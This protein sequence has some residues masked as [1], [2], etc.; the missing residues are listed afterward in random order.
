MCKG[1]GL[2][3]GND[4][5]SNGVVGGMQ[6]DRELRRHTAAA[7]AFDLRHQPNCGHSDL[8]LAE[9]QS[10]WVRGDLYRSHDCIIVVERLPCIQS[11]PLA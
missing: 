10:H 6:A 1:V 9:V 2:V 7:E 11:V 3:D 8:I 4:F 5:V